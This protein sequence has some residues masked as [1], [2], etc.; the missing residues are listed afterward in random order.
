MFYWSFQSVLSK[1]IPL[2]GLE[3]FPKYLTFKITIL[4]LTICSEF[5]SGTLCLTFLFVTNL[6][7]KFTSK[8]TFL[9][10]KLISFFNVEHSIPHSNLLGRWLTW[11]SDPERVLGDKIG[12]RA[13]ECSVCR[14]CCILWCI[15]APPAFPLTFDCRKWCLLWRTHCAHNTI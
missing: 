14:I 8:T 10:H 6:Q 11:K 7:C 13:P 3:E 15:A 2:L 4:C 1:Q 9:L 5:V 12:I